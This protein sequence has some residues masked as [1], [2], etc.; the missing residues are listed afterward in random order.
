MSTL[1]SVLAVVLTLVFLEGVLSIDNAAVIAAM[2]NRLPR[3]QPAPWPVHWL[4]MQRAAA[5]KAGLFGAFVG[6]GLMLACAGLIIRYPM[7]H[8]IGAVYL[9]LLVLEHF[10]GF[11]PIRALFGLF[12]RHETGENGL[13]TL[14]SES[15]WG[16]VL[17]IELADL[18][19]SIDNVIAAV[20]LSPEL[21]VVILG[22]SLGIV[23]MRFAAAGFQWL[24]ERVPTMEHA[25]YLLVLAIAGELLVEQYFDVYLSELQTFGISLAIILAS[26]AYDLLVAR[27]QR[28]TAQPSAIADELQDEA[29]LLQG[30]TTDNV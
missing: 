4:G 16:A 10:T 28:A 15:F 30:H 19:F 7:V 6:R 11:N 25:A 3:R 27:K 26:L 24:I 21:W 1:V 17:S 13:L 9:L 18:A 20:A 2:A 12:S 29:V 22:V 5:L 8:T 14:H 23:T